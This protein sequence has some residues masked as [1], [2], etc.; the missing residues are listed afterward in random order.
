MG[1]VAV[2]SHEGEQGA[3]IM[4]PD[5][6][7]AAAAA[8]ADF[9][10]MTE[11]KRIFVEEWIAKLGEEALDFQTDMQVSCD[12][13]QRR[14]VPMELSIIAAATCRNCRSVCTDGFIVR[15]PSSCKL[16]H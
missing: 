13:V 14:F 12:K 11:E 2:S 6:A 10:P 1:S 9:T 3:E 16:L 7:E 4:D 15:V 8:A 5:E